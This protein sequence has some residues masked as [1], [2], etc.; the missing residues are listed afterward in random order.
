MK[1]RRTLGAILRRARTETGLTQR[2]AAG[3]V[4]ISAV[5]LYYIERGHRVPGPVICRRLA[6]LY[7]LGYDTVGGALLDAT[8]E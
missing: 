8:V 7:N 4:G 1:R 2:E 5:W 3:K 6:D